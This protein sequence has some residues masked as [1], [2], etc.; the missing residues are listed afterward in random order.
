MKNSIFEYELSFIKNP[1]I[2]NFTIRALE[3]LPDYFY[4]VP[5]SSS[6]KY[7]PQYALGQGGLVRHTKAA[8]RIALELFRCET[9]TGHYS[10]NTKDII[11]SALLLHDGCK[12]GLND[13]KYTITEHPI[14]VVEMIRNNNDLNN[15]LDKEIFDKIM[16]GIL[17]HMGQW[18]SDYKTGKEVLE[19]PKTGIQNFIHMC[20]YLASRK[21]IEINF[22]VG[23]SL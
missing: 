9:V 17:T 22:E 10:D 5:A 14:V 2:K 1:D 23:V 7:H 13:S 6:G 12:H 8:V 20:D 16:N 21:S 4:E 15:L 18:T 11:I 3:S 19:K